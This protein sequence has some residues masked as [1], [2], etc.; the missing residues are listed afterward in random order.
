VIALLRHRGLD[1]QARFGDNVHTQEPVL[2]SVDGGL[3]LLKVAVVAVGVVR[4]PLNFIPTSKPA[5]FLIGLGATAK[6]D[7]TKVSL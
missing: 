5:S 7:I 2:D 1:V 3:D 6:S 4:T